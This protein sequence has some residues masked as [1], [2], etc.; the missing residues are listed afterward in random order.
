MT[1]VRQEFAYRKQGAILSA[2]AFD[3]YD[4][5]ELSV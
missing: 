5:L 4:K 1:V 2:L 3:E